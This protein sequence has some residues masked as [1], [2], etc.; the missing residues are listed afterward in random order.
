MKTVKDVFVAAMA[1]IDELDSKGEAQTA[2]TKEYE[3]RTPGIINMMISEKRLLSGEHG[4]FSAVS[5]LSDN[6]LG[7]EDSYA[8]SAMQYGL[9]ANL[10]IDENP[11]AASF[12]Q[13]RYEELR[14]K[15]MMRQTPVVGDVEDVY[16]GIPYGEFSRW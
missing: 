5:G 12:Y 10:L 16:G 11:T 13:Q 4:F 14:D 3:N 2:D 1:L 15:F 6:L 7:I 8:L 9:A